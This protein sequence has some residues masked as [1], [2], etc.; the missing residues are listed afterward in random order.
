MAT[1]SIKQFLDSGVGLEMREYLLG[2]L[3]ELKNIENISDKDT[4]AKQSLEVKAQKRAYAKLKEILQ[5]LMTF[6]GANKV[7]DPR[8]RYSVSDEDLK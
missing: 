8:D 7:R 2:K 5:D 6:Q 3:D 1:E 4:T